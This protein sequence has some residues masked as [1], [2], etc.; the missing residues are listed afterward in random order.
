MIL[1]TIRDLRLPSSEK[2]TLLILTT[3]L[4]NVFPS[5]ETL[6]AETGLSRRTVQT[7]LN[8]LKTRK[9]ID[10]VKTG[11]ANKYEILIVPN[12][13][14]QEQERSA[15]IA[16]PIG[17]HCTSE[18]QPLHTKNQTKKQTK[19]NNKKQKNY[20]EEFEQFYAKYPRKE[21][22]K[23]VAFSRFKQ[24]RKSGTSLE[25]ILSDLNTYIDT[26]PDWQDW[27]YTPSWFGNMM[28]GNKWREEVYANAPLAKQLNSVQTLKKSWQNRSANMTE[29]SLVIEQRR[30]DAAWKEATDEQKKELRELAPEGVTLPK[31]NGTVVHFKTTP[32]MR[33]VQ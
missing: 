31:P 15:T 22:N 30:I 9:L 11:S 33:A 14:L 1:P 10:W 26:K 13:P 25:K 23:N 8:N 20:S 7:C 16:L 2:L 28:F 29:T 12:Q 17:N 32:S 3:H 21:G 6:A 4:P 19:I 5:I 27:A 18:V 24:A